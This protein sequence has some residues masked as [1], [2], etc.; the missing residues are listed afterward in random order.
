[1]DE[2]RIPKYETRPRFSRDRRS[3]SDRSRA[4]PDDLLG[5]V[6]AERTPGA[7][8]QPRAW[9]DDDPAARG[10]SR[11]GRSESVSGAG[12][13]GAARVAA[14]EAV[15]RR[16]IRRR[17]GRRTLWTRRT[18]LRAGTATD[19]ARIANATT[20]SHAREHR[21]VRRA[22]WPHIRGDRRRR[23]Q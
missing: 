23:A 2:G 13:P 6:A 14:E 15:L 1:M 17:P 5:R 12:S 9:S 3:H 7:R 4:E 22:P 11:R 8:R 10:V 19:R 21:S 16:R 20:E 18:R